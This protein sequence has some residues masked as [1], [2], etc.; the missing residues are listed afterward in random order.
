[1]DEKQAIALLKRGDLGGLEVLFHLYQVR[2]VRAACLVTG[3]L[4][5]AEDIVQNAFIR[6]GERI[7]QF[8][9]QRPFEPWFLRSVVNDAIKAANRQKRQVPLEDEPDEA[10][11]FDLVDPSPLPEEIIEKEE[12]AQA[13]WRAMGRL[14][15]NQ[16]AAIVL[17]YY[18]G[19]SEDEMTGEL[20]RPAGTIKSYLRAARQRLGELLHLARLYGSGSQAIPSEEPDREKSYER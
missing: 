4:A 13:V 3:D 11:A 2:A 10:G 5:L 12:T 7:N 19:M 8:D 20:R 16:R 9:S 1:V 14:P 17:R 6:A 15:A 18:L